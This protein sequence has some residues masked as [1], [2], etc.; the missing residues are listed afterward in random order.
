LLHLSWLLKQ[1]MWVECRLEEME[2]L[3]SWIFSMLIDAE[4]LE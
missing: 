4:E 2:E 3:I 1:N